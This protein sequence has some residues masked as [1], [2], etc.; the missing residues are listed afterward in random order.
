[1]KIKFVW[2]FPVLIFY[3]KRLLNGKDG[4]CYILFICIHPDNKTDKGLLMHELTHVK[5]WYRTFG[6]HTILYY[7]SK[8]YRDKAEQEANTIQMEYYKKG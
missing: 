8:K 1:M 3:T 4:Y 7:T 2:I 6:F 5:Q